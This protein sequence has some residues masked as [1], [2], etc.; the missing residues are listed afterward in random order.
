[1]IRADSSAQPVVYSV[2]K[3]KFAPIRLSISINF[4]SILSPWFLDLVSAHRAEGSDDP[5]TLIAIG[6]AGYP[7]FG[8]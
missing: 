3:I 8:F 7:P 6:S 2:S 1:M 5:N 4:L